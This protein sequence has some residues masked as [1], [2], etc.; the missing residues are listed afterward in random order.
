MFLGSTKTTPRSAGRGSQWLKSSLFSNGQTSTSSGIQM[1][2]VAW[3][4]SASPQTIS[5]GQTLF[6]TTSKGCQLP[7]EG[8]VALSPGTTMAGLLSHGIWAHGQHTSEQASPGVGT[9]ALG[10]P[11]NPQPEKSFCDYVNY[12][13]H[14]AVNVLVPFAAQMV[15]LPSLN[16]PKSFWSTQAWSPGRHQL[17]LKVTVKL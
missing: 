4:K 11:V 17:F 9:M 8:G 10:G 16:T 2:M 15:I 12:A 5:G 13:A 6:F 7:G 1:T 3:K 14:I